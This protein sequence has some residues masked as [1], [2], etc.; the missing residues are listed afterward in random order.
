MEYYVVSSLRFSR[1]VK[2]VHLCFRVVGQYKPISH[3]L[4]EVATMVIWERVGNIDIEH[5][6]APF[7]H[8]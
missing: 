4:T 7:F 6:N 5:G 3:T 2:E 8:A 1:K